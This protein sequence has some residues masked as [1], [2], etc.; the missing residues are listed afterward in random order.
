MIALN[1]LTIGLLTCTSALPIG[2]ISIDAAEVD[3]TFTIW[4]DWD[5][6]TVLTAPIG[7]DTGAE[8]TPVTLIIGASSVTTPYRHQMVM[9]SLMVNLPYR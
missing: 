3:G 6:L 4:F 8:A 2:L 7:E 9:S 5:T 1:G